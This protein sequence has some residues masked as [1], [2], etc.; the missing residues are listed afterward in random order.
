MSG[1]KGKC[2]CLESRYSRDYTF[3]RLYLT[4][5]SGRVQ[6]PATIHPILD[7]WTRYP[8]RWGGPR[9]CGIQSLPNTFIHGQHFG[10]NPR[11]SD[12]ESNARST[13]PH[14]F[15]I[16]KTSQP[17]CVCSPSTCAC[18]GLNVTQNV[19]QIRFDRGSNL[20]PPDHNSNFIST[21]F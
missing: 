4:P 8:L 14:A 1:S 6:Q 5:S 20:W 15:I 7:L 2:I 16:G 21:M 13:Q 19:P 9:Q 3:C 12:L 11:P 18:F 17:L 10:S